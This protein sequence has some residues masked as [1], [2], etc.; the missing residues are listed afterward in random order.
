MVTGNLPMHTSDQQLSDHIIYVTANH[1]G[2]MTQIPTSGSRHLEPLKGWEAAGGKG[3]WINSVRSKEDV[4][5]KQIFY[6]L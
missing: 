6:Q 2:H 4:Y 1:I 3:L 5:K